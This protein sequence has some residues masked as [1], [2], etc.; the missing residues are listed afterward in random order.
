[1]PQENLATFRIAGMSLFLLA[2]IRMENHRYKNAV[3]ADVRARDE[4]AARRK[5]QRRIQSGETVSFCDWADG[6][7]R[8]VPVLDEVVECGRADVEYL[9]TRPHVVAR[10]CRYALE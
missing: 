8:S 7:V 1:M 10:N 5:C 6:P 4:H 2:L 3:C 9:S